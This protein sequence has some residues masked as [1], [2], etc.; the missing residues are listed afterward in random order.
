MSAVIDFVKVVADKVAPPRPTTEVRRYDG[1]SRAPRLSNWLAPATDANAAIQTPGA[2]RNRSRD[3][4]RN[5]PW[6]AKGIGVIVN[7][8]VGYGIRAQLKA[9]SA[10]RTRQA[11]SLWNAWAETTACDAD[12]MHDLYGLQAIAMRSLAESGECL[13]R[14]RSRRAEDNLPVPFQL[15]VIEPDLLVDDL[16]GITSVQ[17]SGAVGNNVIQRGIEYD[18]L[19]RRVAYYLYKVHP[20]SDLINLSPA[21][22]TRVPAE[23]I[24]HLYRKDRPGQERGVP[25]LAS[26]IV[27]LRELGIYDDAM[28]K[29]AQIQN[30]FAGFMYSDDPSDMADEMDDEIPDLQPG[31][32]YMMKSGRRIEFSSP[33]PAAEDPQFRDACLRRV[34][35]GLGITFEALTGNLSEVNFSSARLGAMEMGRNVESWQWGLFIPRFCHGVFAWFKQTIAIQGVNTTDL[36]AEWTPPARTLV[37]PNKEWNALLTAVRAGFMTLPEAIRSQGYDPDTV[38]AEQAEY[39]QKLDAA[40]VIVESDYRFDAKPKVSAT[41]TQ[42]GAMNA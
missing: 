39:L 4:V 31:T 3:L 13:I 12:G 2:L 15:Q 29:K 27:T 19:G 22:Y 42:T 5:N 35:A 23:D 41:D 18:T 20:G 14:M 7:N 37:D 32:I 10:L 38:L 21:Q 6:A 33:P 30:L 40:G 26:V 36:T 9:P 28:L 1:G 8:T 34:A 11:Q 17:L 16:S 25:W 24:I